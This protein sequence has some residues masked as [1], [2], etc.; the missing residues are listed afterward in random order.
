MTTPPG[1]LAQRTSRAECTKIVRVQRSEALKTGRSTPLRRP[2]KA[3]FIILAS[4]SRALE[5]RLS[6]RLSER[7]QGH[8]GHTCS[9]LSEQTP[10]SLSG[11]PPELIQIQPGDLSVVDHHAAIRD[12]IE[13]CS[14]RRPPPARSPYR[15]SR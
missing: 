8:T 5:E 12:A 3:G 1:R 6:E 4:L 9:S 14:A 10:Y 15:E 7:G 13:P 11:V 2:K